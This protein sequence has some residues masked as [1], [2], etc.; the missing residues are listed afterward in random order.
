MTDSTEQDHSYIYVDDVNGI[1]LY[2]GEF[3]YY[4]TPYLSNM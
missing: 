1:F 3:T 4:R 2:Q